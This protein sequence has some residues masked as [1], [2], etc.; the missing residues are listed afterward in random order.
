[1]A[2]LCSSILRI[3]AGC[4]SAHR[5]KDYMILP[6]AGGRLYDECPQTFKQQKGKICNRRS[7]VVVRFLGRR[8]FEKEG[9][10]GLGILGNNSVSGYPSTTGISAHKKGS[11]EQG[12]SSIH[13]GKVL[14]PRYIFTSHR[15][16]LLVPSRMTWLQALRGRWPSSLGLRGHEESEHKLHMNW[17]SVGQRYVERSQTSVTWLTHRIGYCD[18]FIL[19]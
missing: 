17:R 11:I 8:A 19:Q 18:I 12:R 1:M 5:L 6:V 14:K 9:Y 2:A 10:A 15:S 7:V 16:V 3:V 13:P 4:G